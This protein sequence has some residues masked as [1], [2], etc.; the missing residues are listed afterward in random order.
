[1]PGVVYGG[2]DGETHVLQGRITRACATCSCD[3]PALIDLKVGGKTPPGD[4]QGP[5]ARTRS[6]TRSCT[7]TCSRC[8]STRR[9]RRTVGVHVEGGEEAPGVKE[10]GVLEH[11]THQ[12][13]IEALPTAI[14]DDI[15][16]DVSGMEIAATM[17]L[18]ELTAARGRRVPRRPRG[19]DHR[20]GRRPDRG[21]GARGDRGGDRAG[22]RGRRADRGGRRAGRGRDRR[23]GRAEGRRGRRGG[24]GLRVSLFRRGGGARLDWL[25]VGLGNPGDRYARTRHNVGFEVAAL[26]A[27]R[28]GMPK[29]KQKYGGLFTDGR[30]GPAARAWRA[31]S[32]DLHERVRQFGR[33]RRAARSAWT[34]TTLSWCTT[35][36]TCRSAAWRSRTGRRPRR[37]TTAS[38]R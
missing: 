16:V 37:A 22:R 19:D 11:V 2:T 33:A 38:S 13:N 18:S 34:S 32:A 23:G 25:V 3:G 29:F 9:S 26:A 31:A 7:S 17:H 24:R 20:H 30:T 15:A 28:W 21:R 5:A 4:R 36:S 10:G 35:R 1:M 27:E 6:A 14:P 12:L 8:A